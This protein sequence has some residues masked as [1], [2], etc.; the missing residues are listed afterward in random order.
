MG[1]I[2]LSR[3]ISTITVVGFLL[4]TAAT[5]NEATAGRGS[6]LRALVKSA[7]LL[8]VSNAI[9]SNSLAAEDSALVMTREELRTCLSIEAKAVESSSKIEH[10]DAEI[11]RLTERKSTVQRLVEAI[12]QKSQYSITS[13]DIDNL[14]KYENEDSY[15]V[16]EGN[17]LIGQYRSQIATHNANI[18]RLNAW[19]CTKKYVAADKTAIEQGL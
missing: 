6:G 16:N 13:T 15:I 19:P 14:K 3:N 4:G 17:K 1:K 5:I 10:L 2:R 12:T 9:D 11:N 7:R 8:A 18:D